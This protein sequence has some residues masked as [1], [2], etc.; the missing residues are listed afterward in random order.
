MYVYVQCSDYLLIMGSGS[1]RDTGR[2]FCQRDPKDSTIF[3]KTQV[4]NH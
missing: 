1:S 3:I 4:P 2:K